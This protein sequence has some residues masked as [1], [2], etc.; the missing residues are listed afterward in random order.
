MTAPRTAY[1]SGGFTLA[2]LLVAVTLLSIVMTS[3]YS[4]THT[5]TRTWR[6]I[7]RGYDIHL[8]ARSFMTLFSHEYNNIVGRASHLFEGDNRRIV[9]FVIAQPMDLEQGEGARLMRVSYAYNANRNIIEREEA[10]VQAALPVPEPGEHA[11]SSG[12]VRLGRRHKT[13][14][15]EHV[16]QFRF[17]YVWAPLP[18]VVAPDE[19]PVPEPLIIQNRHQER[20]GL[21]QA[22]E[23]TLELQDPD[24][25]AQTFSLTTMLPMRAP[26]PRSTREDLENTLGASI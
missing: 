10:L 19:P 15:A 5:A 14:V 2:E 3:V 1:R 12:R 7:E 26:A 23:I 16:K 17:R 25:A 21:P 11:A 13:T 4:L 18:V 9:M 22:V 6:S 24:D 8:E 20:L